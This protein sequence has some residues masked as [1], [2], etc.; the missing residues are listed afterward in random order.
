MGGADTHHKS[1]R[2]SAGAPARALF[3]GKYRPVRIPLLYRVAAVGV[4]LM[5]LVQVVVY[6][7]LIALAC[8]GVWLWVTH[9]TFL[10]DISTEEGYPRGG[11][12]G[13][14]FMLII[15]MIAYIAPI[16]A[17]GTLVLAMLGPLI[18]RRRDR[19]PLVQL[20]RREQR[21]IYA[22]V[23]QLAAVM[24]APNPV[25]IDVICE[26]NAAAAR[27]GGILAAL[28]GKRLVLTIGLS[29]VGGMRRS[30]LTSVIAHELAHFTQ[31]GAARAHTLL[32]LVESWATSTVY[33][34]GVLDELVEETLEDSWWGFQLVALL[35]TICLMLARGV[36]WVFMILGIMMGAFLLRRME[37]DADA[38]ASRVAGARNATWALARVLELGEGWRQAGERTDG[39]WGAGGRRL[40]DNLPGLAVKLAPTGK[41]RKDGFIE[42]FEEQRSVWSSHPPMPDRVAAIARRQDKGIMGGDAHAAA[43]FVDFES[44]CKIATA[45]LYL[46]EIGS[47]Y[48]AAKLTPVSELLEQQQRPG[49]RPPKDD[50]PIPLA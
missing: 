2:Q 38:A 30:E 12:R 47:A 28:F 16:V 35:A 37:Y 46:R 19:Y 22:Y 43:L 32:T 48:Q 42:G 34:R 4:I 20:D 21:F 50:D 26:P 31:G 29:L 23:E 14:I 24:G 33:E 25:R 8:W 10:I 7:G 11:V 9:G 1:S 27:E 3:T 18:P 39:M 13:G 40:P 49:D 15:R 6:L 36:L 5:V 44:L 45:H 41:R 17:G